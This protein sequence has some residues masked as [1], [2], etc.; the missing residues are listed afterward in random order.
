LKAYYGADIHL[1]PTGIV[2]DEREAYRVERMN[3]P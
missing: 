3:K 2:I 1:A